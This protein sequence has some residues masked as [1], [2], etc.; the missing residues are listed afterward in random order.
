[1]LKWMDASD[2]LT[3]SSG[4]NYIVRNTNMLSAYAKVTVTLLLTPSPGHDIALPSKILSPS[5][6]L[7]SLLA[8]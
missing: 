5:P 1:M 4:P 3:V 8:N 2:P 7:P 6:M